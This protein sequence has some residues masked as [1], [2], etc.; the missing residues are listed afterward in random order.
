MKVNICGITYKVIDRADSF[1][2][3]THFGQIEIHLILIHILDKSIS[4]RQS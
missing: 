1:D 3:D 4:A 2:I